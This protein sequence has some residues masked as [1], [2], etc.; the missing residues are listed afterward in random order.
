LLVPPDDPAAL[1]SALEA[2]IRDPMLRRKLG[3]AAEQRVRGDFDY[4]AS[5]EQLSRLFE[6]E[7]Q[8]AS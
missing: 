8:K 1:A 5:I 4:H 7:W 3:D 6:A 2:A